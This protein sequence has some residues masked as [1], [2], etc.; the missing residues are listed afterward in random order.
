MVNTNGFERSLSENPVVILYVEMSNP[1]GL[2][3]DPFF[4]FKKYFV[5]HATFS[6]L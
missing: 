3:W 4:F 2:C 5:L 6:L 1:E